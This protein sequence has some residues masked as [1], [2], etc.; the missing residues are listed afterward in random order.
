[1]EVLRLQPLFLML[2]FYHFRS[3]WFP[4][5]L[6]QI[7][8]I[9]NKSSSIS[10]FQF[11]NRYLLNMAWA[12]SALQVTKQGRSKEMPPGDVCMVKYPRNQTNHGSQVQNKITSL[13]RQAR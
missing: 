4:R 2:T 12:E 3:K 6:D 8:L 13:L 5:P 1:M 10:F 11:F 7:N 9:L